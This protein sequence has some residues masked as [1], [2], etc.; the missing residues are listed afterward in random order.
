MGLIRPVWLMDWA[1]RA[2]S[3]GSTSARPFR[4]MGRSI[5]VR[6]MSWIE[7]R[8]SEFVAGADAQGVGGVDGDDEVGVGTLDV[9]VGP[10]GGDDEGSRLAD[11]KESP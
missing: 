11:R 4:G 9:S 1:R 8:W 2:M 6:G 10:F 7:V 3:A 5:A